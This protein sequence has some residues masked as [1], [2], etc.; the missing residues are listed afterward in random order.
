MTFRA[1][2]PALAL[3]AFTTTGC[4]DDVP[5]L[6][7]SSTM[8]MSAGQPDMTTHAG[9]IATRSIVAVSSTGHDKFYGVA[10]DAQGSFYASGVVADNTTGPYKMVVAKFKADGT[11]DTSFGM[12]GFASPPQTITG[13]TGAGYKVAVQSTGHVILAGA[14][15]PIVAVT[16]PRDRDIAVARFDSN[17]TLDSGFDGDGVVVHALSTGVVDGMKFSADNVWGVAIDSMDRIVLNGAMVRAGNVDTDFVVMRLNGTTGALDSTFNTT[18]YHAL[19]INDR[20][21]TP[22]GVL[23]LANDDVIGCGYYDDGGVVKP[24]IYKLTSA[25]ALDT[26]FASPNG[27]FSQAVLAAVTEVYDVA[28]QGTS[29]V[30]AGYGRNMAGPVDVVSL[31]VT[32]AGALDSTYGSSGATVVDVAGANDRTRNVVA[33]ADGRLLLV[34][35]GSPVDGNVDALMLMLTANGAKDTTF[36]PTGYLLEDLGGANDMLWQVAVSPDGKKAVA[37]GEKAGVTDGNDDA[38]VLTLDLP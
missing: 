36:T 7:G 6:D 23:V 1:T 10:F 21:A 18:G 14:V 28:L 9:T 38:A 3:L 11:L 31:R 4:D 20:S 35:G 26:N 16:D 13:S 19:N 37:V 15:D 8:D 2:L 29:L 25:G 33:L 27:Y 32:S 30:T 17:G 5:G 34:G 22:K 12:N 24:A